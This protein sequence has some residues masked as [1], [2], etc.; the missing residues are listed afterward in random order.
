MSHR[1]ILFDIDGTILYPGTL[2]R[3][4]LD[5]AVEEVAGESPQLEVEDVAGFTDPVI[6]R[7]ALSRIGI[8]G[9]HIP[10]NVDA[11]LE[12]YLIALR[13]EYPL[14]E[15]PFLYDDALTLADQCRRKGWTIALLSGNLRD[16]ARV[17]LDRFDV[18][19]DFA[20]GVFGDDA[21]NRSD[22][23]WIVPEV[24]WDVL[25]EAYKHSDIILIG[26]TP[27]DARIARENSSRSLIVCRR[28]E[29]WDK[30]KAEQPTWLVDSLEDTVAI[31]N[32]ME[33]E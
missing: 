18:W 27:N 22:L 2:A 11:V 14:Y 24:A 3:K 25:G 10:G 4:L 21:A 12:N 28:Q 16:G 31:L 23:L 20:F 29:W 6:I 32:W 7:N 15:E 26:D 17:K 13:K 1:L 8:T 30:I 9:D 33:D 19:D 5:R